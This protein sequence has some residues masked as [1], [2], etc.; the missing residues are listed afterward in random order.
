MSTYYV[1]GATGNDTTGDGSSG[2]PWATISKAMTVVAL[3]DVVYVKASVVYYETVTIPSDVHCSLIGYTTTPG[4]NGRAIIDGGSSR[5]N[6]IVD[7]IGTG[8]TAAQYHFSNFEIRNCT[9]EGIT[10][11]RP[12][13]GNEP[14]L[15]LTLFNIHSHDNAK[16]GALGISSYPNVTVRNCR[17]NHNGRYGTYLQ[18]SLTPHINSVAHDNGASA[19]FGGFY[20]PSQC[21]NCIAYANTGF[22]IAGHFAPLINCIAYNNGTIGFEG[23]GYGRPCSYINCISA[24]NGTYGI[25]NGS[26]TSTRITIQLSN[27]FIYNNVSGAFEDTTLVAGGSARPAYPTDLSNYSLSDPGLANPA[28]NNFNLASTLAAAYQSEEFGIGL[29]DDTYA[30]SFLS[31]GFE[32]ENTGGGGGPF[33]YIH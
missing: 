2:N 1:D 26:D 13:A 27:C 18:G 23:Y 4:D 19:A 8:G 9:G 28:S 12:G 7:Q 16:E 3:G 29:L 15:H 5:S 22:G 21:Y 32:L 33:A 17:F 14:Y 24:S 31:A 20:R 30:S 10:L 25:G 6:G 11:I